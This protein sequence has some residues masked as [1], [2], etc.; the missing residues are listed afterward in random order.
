MEKGK[1]KQGESS[2]TDMKVSV[3]ENWHWGTVRCLLFFLLLISHC[4]LLQDTE[5]CP[6]LHSRSSSIILYIVCGRVTPK[7]LICRSPSF[8]PLVTVSSF[9][10]SVSLFLFCKQIHL[11]H[12]LDS[13]YKWCTIVFLCLTYFSYCANVWAQYPCCCAWHHFSLP[14]LS[15][16]P[17]RVCTASSLSFNL[18]VGI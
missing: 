18:S 8:P 10:V 14:R 7:L 13:T 11:C 9:S 1:N 12:F 17:L 5:I 4:S 15:R 6:V 16:V 3:Q 2:Y